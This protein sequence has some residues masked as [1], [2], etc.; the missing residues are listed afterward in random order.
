MFVVIE[1][2]LLSIAYAEITMSTL[3]PI[4]DVKR[5]MVDN[6]RLMN[7]IQINVQLS[8]VVYLP[9]ILAPRICPIYRKEEVC[10]RE[11][12]DIF[13]KI[14]KKKQYKVLY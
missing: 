9:T 7:N 14:E 11:C 2:I 8:A 3:S 10:I 1:A 12:V 13:Y 5:T 6:V 4:I